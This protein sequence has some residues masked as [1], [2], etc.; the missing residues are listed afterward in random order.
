V[1]GDLFELPKG[2]GVEREV[3]ATPLIASLSQEGPAALKYAL[4]LLGFMAPNTRLPIVE[5]DDA[6]KAAVA[7]AI[8]EIRDEDIACPSESWHGDH[9]EKVSAAMGRPE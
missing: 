7:D 5:L 3:F 8:L 2:T 4:C 6:A 9:I 1:P